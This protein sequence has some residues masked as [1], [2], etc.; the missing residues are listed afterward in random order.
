MV[1]FTPVAVAL[2]GL[3]TYPGVDAFA[4][5][6]AG[7]FGSSLKMVR[8]LALITVSS[9]CAHVRGAS[10]K[11]LDEHESWILEYCT[12]TTACVAV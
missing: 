6:K 2:L 5:K 11:S 9:F 10:W 12:K 1:S 3:A 8:I 7:G 4:P